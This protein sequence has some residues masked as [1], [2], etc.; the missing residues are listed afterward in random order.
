VWRNANAQTAISAA[1]PSTTTAPIHVSRRSSLIQRG[2]IVEH[3]T[4]PQAEAAAD[5]DQDQGAGGDWNG[6][7]VGDAEVAEREADADEL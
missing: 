4:L 7:V 3:R 2:V 5:G 1:A 6:H